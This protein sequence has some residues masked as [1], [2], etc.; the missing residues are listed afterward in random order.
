MHEEHKQLQLDVLPLSL[1]G[2]SV[3]KKFPP[4]HDITRSQVT[5]IRPK[6]K[7]IIKI[8]EN[9]SR[10]AGNPRS[11]RTAQRPFWRSAVKNWSLSA[12]FYRSM[13]VNCTLSTEEDG[14]EV[15]AHSIKVDMAE[16]AEVEVQSDRIKAQDGQG[17][18]LDDEPYRVEVG[19]LDY[20]QESNDGEMD[21]KDGES[22]SD[23][24]VEV[25]PFLPGSDS[26]MEE[27]QINDSNWF[28]DE[29]QSEEL[30]SPH[31][32][33]EDSEHEGYGHFS[34]FSQPKNMVDFNWEVRTYFVDKEDILD[35]IKS[36][37]IE[38]EKNLKLVK[39]DK[40]RIRVMGVAPHAKFNVHKRM[41]YSTRK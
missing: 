31:N 40:K 12:H 18:T 22:C 37:A 20:V 27:D 34:T 7:Q 14:V 15:Q 5:E 38:N 41:Q 6:T 19:D 24:E 4:V 26:D 8:A 29:W 17:D 16:A 9:R 23:L 30:T 25:K 1:G 11:R 21:S 32:S 2:I 35:A 33:D 28:N 13:L 39:N 36:Y 3:F 10:S